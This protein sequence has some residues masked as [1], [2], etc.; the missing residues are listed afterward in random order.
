MVLASIWEKRRRRRHIAQGFEQGREAANKAWRDWLQRRDAA[1]ANGIPF[2]ESTPDSNG[3][4]NPP[5][6]HPA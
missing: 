1:A 4:T 3:H 6:S 2:D 5:P